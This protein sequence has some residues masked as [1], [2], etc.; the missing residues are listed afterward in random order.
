MA[1]PTG[2]LRQACAAGAPA[3]PFALRCWAHILSI[4]R[5][6]SQ[7]IYCS[8]C[9]INK[10]RETLRGWHS[11]Q[12]TA[13]ECGAGA[14]E[15][16]GCGAARGRPARPHGHS[17]GC[18]PVGRAALTLGTG[19]S[20]RTRSTLTFASALPWESPGRA[21]RDRDSQLCRAVRTGRRGLASPRPPWAS[22]HPQ[23]NPSV[24]PKPG[25]EFL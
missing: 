4:T 12:V 8:S 18:R 1:D 11:P 20:P 3:L 17:D 25:L 21:G 2:R 24:I 5:V 14:G 16:P 13:R 9:S 10:K 7:V 15:P 19:G 23:R 6:L 22:R